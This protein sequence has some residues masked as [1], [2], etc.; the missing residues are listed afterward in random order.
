M[1]ILYILCAVVIAQVSWLGS[2]PIPQKPVGKPVVIYKKVTQPV[3]KKNSK[4]VSSPQTSGKSAKIYSKGV[5]RRPYQQSAEIAKI[6][7]HALKT[8]AHEQ[9]FTRN[10]TINLLDICHINDSRMTQHT[11]GV[12][13]WC[14][15]V[16]LE[17][18]KTNTAHW[19][20]SVP[21]G[22]AIRTPQGI[23]ARNASKDAVIKFVCSGN[24]ISINGTKYQPNT[25][26]IEPL[27]GQ[28]SW[29]NKTYPGSLG[30]ARWK[31]TWCLINQVPLEEYV[32][33][34]LRTESWP[35]WPIVVNR[36][37]AIASRSYVLAQARQARKLGRPYHI[38]NTNAHQTYSG[39]HDRQDLRQAVKDTQG[40]Y[41][42]YENEPIL[43]MFD[44]CCGGIIPAHIED[45]NFNDAP[46]LARTYPCNFCKSSKLYSWNIEYEIAHIESCIKQ[47]HNNFSSFKDI[48]SIVKDKAGLVKHVTFNG[49]GKPVQVEGKK[50]Y[51]LID[52][53]KS[54]HFSVK[55]NGKKIAFSGKG[56]G[57]HIGLCQWGAREMVRQGWNHLQILNFYY[58]KTNLV[59][60]T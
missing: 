18:Q 34:V 39:F 15:K 35:G 9:P 54:F 57:H 21:G 31:E 8:I 29:N 28:I 55:R 53:I 58:P 20:I 7:N 36:A 56:Y 23:A 44:C 11:K 38:R 40:Q 50:I 19:Q 22:Y 47:V 17:Q 25:T 30:I 16:M 51:S 59:K 27:S 6:K 5:P 26:W 41:L 10:K 24:T 42:C 49:K 45:F 14:V 60:L 13:M 32:A 33:C 52:G 43:A 48:K 12:H 4:I 46:Y 3:V 37:F 2:R 1:N